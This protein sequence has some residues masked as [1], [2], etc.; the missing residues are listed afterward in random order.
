[1]LDCKVGC[2]G[3]LALMGQEAGAVEPVAEVLRDLQRLPQVLL[4]RFSFRAHRTLCC[5]A[6]L[7]PVVKR[8]LDLILP[9]RAE[10]SRLGRCPWPSYAG[11]GSC[12]F[13]EGNQVCSLVP[14]VRFCHLL[15]L[16]LRAMLRTRVS[17]CVQGLRPWLRRPIA[18]SKW[19]TPWLGMDPEQGW[20]SWERPLPWE[21]EVARPQGPL[22]LRSSLVFTSRSHGLLL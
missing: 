22:L 9:G 20:M 17:H 3:L 19:A 21:A 15:R 18:R 14:G 13:L 8:S 11:P 10:D 4:L 2:R 7:A 1:M 6:N 16:C 12:P 5:P